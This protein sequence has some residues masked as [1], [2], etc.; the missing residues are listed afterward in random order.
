MTIVLFIRQSQSHTHF[1]GRDQIAEAIET[2]VQKILHDF[3]TNLYVIHVIRERDGVKLISIQ[4]R[5]D[6]MN[7]HIFGGAIFPNTNNAR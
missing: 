2:Y 7:E 6:R 4:Y 3:G 1:N 5:V